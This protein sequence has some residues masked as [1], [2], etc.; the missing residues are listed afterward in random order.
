MQI[1]IMVFV[2]WIVGLVLGRIGI[3]LLHRLKYGQNVREEGLESHKVKQGTPTIGGLIFLAT[4]L[5]S[6][7]IWS[8]WQDPAVLYVLVSI[9][10]FSAIG[11]LDDYLKIVRKQNEGLTSKQKLLL[12]FL[13]AG[14][15]SFWAYT[16]SSVVV[17]PFWKAID[18][19]WLFLPLAFI[20]YI[21]ITNAVNLTDGADG[22]ATSVTVIVVALGAVIAMQTGA[23]GLFE[24]SLILATSLIAFLAY[25]WYPAKVIMGDTGSLALGGYIGAVSL[26]LGIPLFIPIFGIV[27]V[28]E[29]LSVLMQVSYYKRTKKR[30]FKMAPIHHHFELSGW[31]EIKIVSVFSAVTL[32]TC[33]I[34]FIIWKLSV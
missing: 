12:Q 26:M 9:V 10:A 14:L 24:F 23:I 19:G 33:L 15:L 21:S 6:V 27:Y 7:L 30:I 17:V 25:N 1:F 5:V 3:R 16:M 2:T 34:S 13:V 32:I 29:N 18:F 11:F 31:T 4:T 22:L 8:L 28:V 20:M